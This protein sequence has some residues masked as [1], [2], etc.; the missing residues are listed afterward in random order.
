MHWIDIAEQ[1]SRSDIEEEKI[2]EFEDIPIETIK[3]K[4]RKENKKL[5]ELSV[6]YEETS[7]GLIYTY[8]I[9]MGE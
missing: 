3:M 4:Q 2:L 5:P 9:K 7:R 8:I 1:T 6:S